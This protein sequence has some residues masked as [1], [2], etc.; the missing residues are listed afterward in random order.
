MIPRAKK[1]D[2]TAA[3]PTFEQESTVSLKL[4]FFTENWQKF[5]PNCFASP[6]GACYIHFLPWIF[7]LGKGTF[8]LL[9]HLVLGNECD[10]MTKK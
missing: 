7:K 10:K 2:I 6:I 9:P 8:T 4:D 5:T 1:G 3:K